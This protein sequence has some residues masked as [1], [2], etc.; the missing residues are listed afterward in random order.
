MFLEKAKQLCLEIDVELGYFVE[1]QCS[2]VSGLDFPG[3]FFMC[4]GECPF[5]PAEEFRL[6][7]VFWNGGGVQRDKGPEFPGAVV[8]DAFCDELLAR[9]AFS[10]NENRYILWGDPA[11]LF[12][13]LEYSFAFADH[14][15]GFLFLFVLAET[16]QFV[17]E[18]Y[19]AE[20]LPD[21]DTQFFNV[22]RLL[23]IIVSAFPHCFDCA[24]HATMRSNHDN[25]GVGIE[26]AYFLE[27]IQ[28]A[29]IR[30][31]H[32]EQHETESVNSLHARLEGCFLLRCR[33]RTAREPC[34]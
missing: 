21:D 17:A 30:K 26:D 27:R 12:E 28:S 31:H 34:G 33:N 20:G 22:E 6:E 18:G 4:S 29:A 14:G 3:I 2:S 16:G 15:R 11:Y 1:Q 19:V 5:F 8:M 24:F 7:Q 32:V 25:K 13:N 9:T 23:K 10:R